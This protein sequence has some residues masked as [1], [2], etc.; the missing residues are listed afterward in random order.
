MFTVRNT[1]QKKLLSFLLALMFTAGIALPAGLA[2]PALAADELTQA[3]EQ[4]VL[5]VTGMDIIGG[6]YTASSV[7]NER[8]YTLAEL[9]NLGITDTRYYSSLNSAG[10]KRIYM[11]EG[12]DAASLLALSDYTADTGGELTFFAS[13]GYTVKFDSAVPLNEGRQY[14]PNLGMAEGEDEG[15]EAVGTLLAWQSGYVTAPGVPET[16]AAERPMRLLAGQTDLTNVNNSL[17]NQQLRTIQAGDAVAEAAINIL[18]TDYT[19]AE[20]LMMPRAERAYGSTTVRGVPLSVLLNGLSDSAVIEF[21]TADDYDVAATGMTKAELIAANALLVYETLTDSVWTGYYRAQAQTGTYPAYFRLYADGLTAAHAIDAVS[22]RPVEAS[23][24]KHMDYDGAPYHIDAI[25]GATLTVEGPGVVASVPIT[26]EYLE[27]TTE[28]NIHKGVYSDSRGSGSVAFSYEGVTLQSILDGQVNSIVERLDDSVVVV[29]KNRWREEMGRIS[30]ADILSADTPLIMAYG[31]ASADETSIPPRPFVFNMGAGESAALGNGD[32]PLKLVYDQ[33]EFPGLAAKSAKFYSVAY[34]YIEEGTPPPGFKHTTATNEAYSNK[35]NTEYIV[36]FTGDALGREVNY[37]VA[38]LE[39]MVEY[40]DGAPAPGGKGHRDNYNL[41]NTT[42]WYVNEYEGVKVWDLLVG[43][44]VDPAKYANDEDTLVSFSS[45]DNYLI[46][47]QFSMYQLANPGLFYFY[48]KSPLDIGTDR[49]TK[50]Q[51]ATAEYQPDNRE[52]D[53]WVLDDNGYPV[54]KGYPVLLAYGLNGY[55]YVRNPGMNGYMSGLGNSGGPMR[56][57]YGKTD[58]LNRSN[59]DA[60]ENYAYFFNN[61]SQQLQRVQEVYVGNP[62]RYSTH[63]E[64]PLEA[65][66]AMKDQSAA[67]TVEVVSAGVTTPYTFSLAE[68]ESILYG[69]GVSKRDRDTEGRQEKGYYTTRIAGTNPIH[70]LYEGINLEYLLTEYIGLQGTLGTVEMYSGDGAAPESIYSLADIGEKGYNAGRGTEGLGMMV[71]F[72]KNGFPLVDGPN[73]T[74]NPNPGYVHNDPLDNNKGIRN[75]VGPLHFVRPQ[76][77]DERVSNTVNG[78]TGDAKTLVENLTRIVVN[79][80]PDPYAHT[81]AANEEYA[82]QE[83]QFNGAIAFASG[84]NLPVGVLETMQKYMVTD[85]YTVDGVTNTYRGLDLFRLLN[86][87]SVGASALM[88]EITVAN[89]EGQSK[90]L[91]VADLTG[92][93]KKVI[94]AYGM[95]GAVDTSDAAPLTTDTGGPI[96]LVIDGGDGDDCISGVT[97][98]SVSAASLDGWKHTSGNFAEYATDTLEISGQNLKS[99][100]TY[101]VAEIED[102]DNILV[103]DQYQVGGPTWVQGID[104]YKLLQNIGFAGDLDTSAFTANSIDNY[105]ITFTGAQLKDGINGKPILVAYG[106]GTSQTNGLPLVPL[107][108]SPGYDP[109]VFNSSGPLRL[110][111]HDNTGWCVKWLTKITVGASGGTEE[112]VDELDF[113][114]YGLSGGTVSYDIRGLKNSSDFDGKAVETYSYASSGNTVTDTVRGAYLYDILKA[115]GV[116]DASTVT[117]NT[118]DSFESSGRGDDYCDITMAEIKDMKYFVAYDAGSDADSMAA[119]ADVRNEITAT[120][121][122]YRNYS[123]PPARYN[124]MTDIKGVTVAGFAFNLYPGGVDGVPQA[125]VRAVVAD[126]AGGIW[127]GTNG[128]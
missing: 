70:E 128:A 31:T 40:E 89:G 67:L 68:L 60:E 82:N 113:N 30:Y 23:A 9:Q 4:P 58:G 20:I 91:T 73:S 97:E 21:H 36:T 118:T 35:L 38:E 77:A 28:D 44:G 27:K 55:P 16:M 116:S 61:G 51:L 79:L 114:I 106:M 12:A 92:V 80:D 105:P 5:L 81:G 124:R 59:P 24:Y 121:R 74:A 42:Y 53:G 87:K 47:A 54:K 6:G 86:D 126:E 46:S 57:I 122:I 109:N 64:N 108:T 25:T 85:T 72:A 52:G 32:G 17:F 99:N 22:E 48:E 101:T 50:E 120:V 26:V 94:L 11:G 110:I 76:T 112:P 125:S 66:Q 3:L 96:R 15:A 65:Y 93:G 127:L 63:L 71:A 56:V 10:T 123:D 37:T 95:A 49:P 98:I 111:V 19:R 14:F 78:T 33:D 34:L 107:E 84:V 119:I 43:M 18:D 2:P 62:L 13:D 39:A 102:M 104:L 29:F 88:D 8:S 100:K 7:S 41:S 45:W 117:V 103:F 115:N 75:G 1:W 83:L 69:E 90:S